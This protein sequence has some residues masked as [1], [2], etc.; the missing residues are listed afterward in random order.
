MKTVILFCLTATFF[1]AL[2]VGP[3]II[4]FLKKIKFGQNIRA[5][6]PKRHLS[7]AGTPTMG[8]IIIL[9]PLILTGFFFYRYADHL[10]LLVGI[11]LG[12]GLIG[13]AD[14]YIKVALKR[15]LGL[16]AKQKILFQL[17]L[18]A[19]FLYYVTIHSEVD[20]NILVPFIKT[21][22]NLG[23]FYLPFCILV[24]ISTVNSANLTDGLDGLLAGITIIISSGYALI[25]YFIKD[26]NV[27]IF[28]CSLIGALLGFMI[29]NKH[30]A[31]VFMGDT[32]SLAIGGALASIAVI[33]KTQLFLPL[34]GFIFV[35]EALSVIIQVFSFRL[36][37]KRVFKMS[38]LHHHFEL[39]GW[40]EQ[41]VVF[42]FW[43]LTFVSVL[44][45]LLAYF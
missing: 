23:S 37:G 40:Q 29:Y 2:L 36:F 12:F 39:K 3:I 18:S 22:L 45:G 28:S 7:K 26:Y 42:L 27:L 32:G 6:G 21:K 24:I 16:R 44:I 20:T 17:I 9:L 4:P 5:Q 13:F 31:K 34:F 8:G 19:I 41:N 30:P 10:I 15:P 25:G 33:T 11:T 43:I 35:L 38:P 1:V 14:D